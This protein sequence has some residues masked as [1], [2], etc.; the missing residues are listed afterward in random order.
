[1]L[2]QAFY[3]GATQ[4][5]QSTID[6]TVGGTLMNKMEDEAYSL[7]EDMALNSY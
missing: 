1:M 3:S 2:V 7:I 5:V 6:A 4:P